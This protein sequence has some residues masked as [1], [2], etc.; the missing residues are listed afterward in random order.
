MHHQPQRGDGRRS[1]EALGGAAHVLRRDAE[2]VHTRVDLEVHV[3]RPRELRL[4]ED[5]HLVER[6]DDDAERVR[7]DR[8]ELARVEEALEQQDRALVAALAQP[9]RGVQLDQRQ[10]VGRR[11]RRQDAVESVPVR[12][13]LDDGEDFGARG[14]GPRAGEVGLQRCEVDVRNERSGHAASRTTV[15]SGAW[16]AVR[17]RPADAG[18]RTSR[19]GKACAFM[20]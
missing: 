15:P 18:R 9:Q 11:E 19:V 10:P 8:I 4:L 17:Y 7:R 2:P 14:A 3:E 20:V 6:M 1:R 5:A 12:V 13:G 16:R